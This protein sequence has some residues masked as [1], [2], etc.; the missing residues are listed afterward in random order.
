[1]AIIQWPSRIEGGRASADIVTAMDLY[2]TI[3]KAAGAAVPSDRPVDGNDLTR[4]LKGE[5][6]SPT[7]HYFYFNHE[8]LEGVREGRWKL[9]WTREDSTGTP[10]I[11]LFDLEIDPGEMYDRK[12]EFPEVVSRL[13]EKMKQFAAELGATVASDR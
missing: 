11:E 13:R 1:T 5:E 3:L 2:V 4:F 10:L 12:A 9:R 6:P 7:K 8:R